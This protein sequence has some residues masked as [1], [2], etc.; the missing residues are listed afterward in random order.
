MSTTGQ[1]TFLM[2]RQLIAWVGT[3]PTPSKQVNLWLG[4][5]LNPR[6]SWQVNTWV[7]AITLG[8]RE[9][10][11]K[12]QNQILPVSCVLIV[13]IRIGLG[14]GQYLSVRVGVMYLSVRVGV[15]TRILGHGLVSQGSCTNPQ[16]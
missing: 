16:Q 7:D 9:T 1:T 5:S 11:G 6:H 13:I 14:L 12:R 3:N 10:W 2:P 4:V 15:M 8:G